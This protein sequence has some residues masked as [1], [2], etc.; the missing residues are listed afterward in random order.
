MKIK[1]TENQLKNLTKEIISEDIF[2]KLEGRNFKIN[3]DGTISIQDYKGGMPKIR[4][5]TKSFGNVNIE[6]IER[7]GD[8]YKLTTKKGLEKKISRNIVS[9]IIKFVDTNEPNVI[10]TG[11]MSPNLILNKT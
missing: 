6:K 1:I 10:D 8:E 2:N 11:F 7:D 4:I 5:S 9:K 3:S